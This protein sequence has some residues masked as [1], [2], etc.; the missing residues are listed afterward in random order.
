[1][2][3]SPAQIAALAEISK[4]WPDRAMVIIGATALGLF[5]EMRWRQTADLDLVIAIGVDDLQAIAQRPGW[6]QSA[7]RQHEFRSPQGARM[8]ILPAAAALIERGALAWP[9]GH[10]M[11]LAGMDLAFV[12]AIAHDLGAGHRVRVAPPA[13]VTVLKMAAHGDRPTERERDLGDIA[14]LLD[15]YVEAD[16]N[17]RWDEA[18][19]IEY[20]LAPAFLLGLDLG[21]LAG[22]SHR[23]L[24]AQFL[25]RVGDPDSVHHAQMERLGPHS[26]RGE[27]EALRRRLD[28]FRQ[29]FEGTSADEG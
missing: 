2:S 20:D 22:E 11:S 16:S 12:H 25:D 6:Q 19:A 14:Y 29:G 26:W 28:A 9:S 24:V 5:V 23:A 27:E 15:V 13:V 21:R 3:L 4:I 7:L 17:R 10:V 18:A 1:V 8:D